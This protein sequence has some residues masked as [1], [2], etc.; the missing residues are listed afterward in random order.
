M[1]NVK[2]VAKD[3]NQL[4]GENNKEKETTTKKTGYKTR[5]K[6]FLADGETVKLSCTISVPVSDDEMGTLVNN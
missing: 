2:E 1:L 4:L 6:H 3:G 5:T